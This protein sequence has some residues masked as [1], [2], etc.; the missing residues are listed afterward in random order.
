[1]SSNKRTESYELG[2]EGEE[3]AVSYLQSHGY[4]IIERRWHDHH[5]EIDIFAIDPESREFVSIEVKTRS[6]IEWGNPEDAVDT[7]K[8]R[9]TVYAT[10]YYMKLHNVQQ[11]VRFDIIAVIIPS[12]GAKPIINHIKEAFYPPL[13]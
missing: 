6:S 12:N 11:E 10:D 9:R 2:R 8:I 7:K 13:G 1:M 4:Q 5:M 3:M